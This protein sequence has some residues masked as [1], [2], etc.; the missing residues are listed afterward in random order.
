[1]ASLFHEIA[2]FGA[3]GAANV[4]IDGGIYNLLRLTKLGDK[5]LTAAIISTTIAIVSSYLMNRHWTW[6]HTQRAH[7]GRELVLFFAIS[8]VGLVI[9]LGCLWAS[10]YVLG[11]TSLLADNVAKNGF[12]LVLGMVWRFWAFKRWIFLAVEAEGPAAT[13]SADLTV[14]TTI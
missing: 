3:V 8:G 4:V 11:F 6:R 12:G 10:H 2:K 1:M 14:R 13:D 7:P 9:A 5:P